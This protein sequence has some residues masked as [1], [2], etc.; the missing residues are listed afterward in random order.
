MNKAQGE[1]SFRSYFPSLHLPM[2]LNITADSEGI[3]IP[4]LKILLLT[5]SLLCK[6]A[7]CCQPS[8]SLNHKCQK[9]PLS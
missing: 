8:D 5:D 1:T 7:D 4:V 6:I 9:T 3:I 2:L